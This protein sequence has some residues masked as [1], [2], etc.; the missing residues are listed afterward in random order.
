MAEVLGQLDVVRLVEGSAAYYVGVYGGG[1]SWGGYAFIN[2]EPEYF[3]PGSHVSLIRS[4]LTSVIAHELGHNMGR[5]HAP[6]ATP[7]LQLDASYPNAGGVTNISG[8][9]LQRWSV[10]GTFPVERLGTMF[11][12]MSY[13]LPRWVSEYTFRGLLD[14]RIREDSALAAMATVAPQRSLVI[15]GSISNDSIRLEPSF[16]ANV[17]PTAPPERGAFTLDGADSRGVKLF[18]RSFDPAIV[19]HSSR[20]TFLF[21]V[22]LSAAEETSLAH[23]TVVGRGLTARRALA[24]A[25]LRLRGGGDLSTVSYKAAGAGRSLV[26]WDTTVHPLIIARDVGRD[27]IL[28]IGT[29]GRLALATTADQVELIVSNGLTSVVRTLRRK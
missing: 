10:D 13:C 15:W 25:A 9:D 4:Q 6:C 21:A 23:L 1:T 8:A 16:I 26:S 27:R 28:G 11:D 20:R 3:G 2:S 24:P 22:P 18:S 14:W 12:F 5:W 17:R 19:D 29:T 7:A